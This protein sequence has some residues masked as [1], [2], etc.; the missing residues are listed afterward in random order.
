MTPPPDS[1][2][3]MRTFVVIVGPPAVGKMAVGRALEEITGLPVFRNHMSIELVLPFFEFGS[4]PF[5]RLVVGFREQFFREV[6]AS[7][8]P[9]L[10]FTWVWAFDDEADRRFIEGVRDTFEGEGVR[11]VFVEL[12]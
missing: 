2:S 3:I 11:T 7:D 12:V 1:W 4:D 8:L 6:A 9:G 10:I 5:S